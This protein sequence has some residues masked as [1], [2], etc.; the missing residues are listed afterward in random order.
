MS[1]PRLVVAVAALL[2]GCSPDLS[3]APNPH[4]P[5]APLRLAEG[6]PVAYV[7]EWAWDGA[8]RE[9]GAYVFETDRGYTIG[10]T[11]AH[12]ALGRVELVPCEPPTPGLVGAVSSLLVPTAHAAHARVGDS[13][14]V[15]SPLVESLLDPSTR[16]YGRGFAGADA[17]CGVHLLGVPL[18]AAGDDGFALARESLVLTGFWSAPGSRERHDLKARIN[19]Q[20]GSVRPLSGWTSWPGAL[21]RGR[22]PVAVVITRHPARAF[23]RLA[24]EQLGELDLGFEVLGNLMQ[25]AEVRIAS[26][27]AEP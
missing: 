26:A 11:A 21:P 5:A 3:L 12:A 27:V 20:D 22:A 8:H 23:D 19:L 15:A 1:A 9:G 10:I 24:L 13:S 4:G 2:G 7:L 17:Y 16:L 6:S 25:S 18:A 14:A